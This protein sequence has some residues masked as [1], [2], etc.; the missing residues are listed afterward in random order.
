MK[1]YLLIAVLVLL[2][3]Q[4]DN[5]IDDSKNITSLL[6]LNTNEDPYEERS[7]LLPFEGNMQFAIYENYTSVNEGEEQVPQ[8]FL[9]MRTEKEYGCCNYRIEGN[10]IID[11]NAV[12]YEITG[13]RRPNTCLMAFGP[14]GYSAP[15]DISEGDCSLKFIHGERIDEYKIIITEESIQIEPIHNEFTNPRFNQYWR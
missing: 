7:T 6:P 5:A 14:A 15:L 2:T 10:I 12:S 4:C 3:V 1:K 13:I 9:S 8:I 11:D